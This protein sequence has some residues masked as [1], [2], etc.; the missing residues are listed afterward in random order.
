MT[1]RDATST[2][3]DDEIEV[4][5]VVPVYNSA[6]TLSE[7]VDRV[8]ATVAAITSSYELVLV[9]DG[10]A[11]ASWEVMRDLATAYP[12]VMA[13]DLLRNHGQDTAT[14]CGLDL[15][16]GRLVATLDDDLQQPPEEL[17]VLFHH[18]ADRPDLDAVVGTWERDQGFV[19]DVGTKVNALLDRLSNGTP[20]GFHHTAF[21]VMRRATVD[22]ILASRT[23][24]PIVWALLTQ[25]T[26]RVEN[27]EVRHA[28]R[29]QGTSGYTIRAAVRLVLKNFLQGTT[30]P[31]RIL[32]VLGLVSSSI[33][34][35]LIVLLVGRW[36]AGVATPPGWASSTL[37]VTFFGGMTLFG[38]GLIGEYLRLLI[39]EARSARWTVRT[40]VGQGTAS[41]SLDRRT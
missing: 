21:R 19:R 32:S 3:R 6:P 17:A 27:V 34:L 10:S 14:M 8:R 23:R 13:V 31:L 9:N 4:S 12:E 26:T 16:H 30:L 7:L 35:L 15:A 20:R 40:V 25:S 37:A 41:P 29:A 2:P 18:L 38:L 24:T 28:P 11:D 5:V 39:I 36:V 22:A 33:A 1:V